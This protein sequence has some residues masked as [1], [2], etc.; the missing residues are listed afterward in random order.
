[1]TRIETETPDG[2]ETSRSS[3]FV[4]KK[5]WTAFFL[6]LTIVFLSCAVRFRSDNFSRLIEHDELL[7]VQDY[8]W[9]GVNADGTRHEIRNISDLTGLSSCSV[10]QFAIG[11]YCSLGRWIEPN[12]HAYHSLLVNATLA[13]MDEKIEASRLPALLAAAG[14]G[15]VCAGLCCWA[16]YYFTAPLVTAICLWHPYVVSFSQSCRGYALVLF[17]TALSIFWLSQLVKNSRSKL[18]GCLMAIS[19]CVLLMTMVNLAV[20]WVAP[21][22]LVTFVFLPMLCEPNSSESELRSIRQNLLFQSLGICAVG[23]VF[24][25]DR[26]PYLYASATQYGIPIETFSD[27]IGRVGILAGYLFPTVPFKLFAILSCLGIITACK[28]RR[29]KLLIVPYLAALVISLAH[30][31]ITYR[32]PY[33]RNIGFVLPLFLFGYASLTETAIRFFQSRYSQGATFVCSILF[34]AWCLQ[35]SLEIELEDTA[36]RELVHSLENMEERSEESTLVVTGKG[37]PM[38]VKLY[39]P[40]NWSLSE[41]PLQDGEKVTV[42]LMENQTRPPL[43]SSNGETSISNLLTSSWPGAVKESIACYDQWTLPAVLHQAP[44]PEKTPAFHMAVWYPPFHVVSVS[45][46][47]VLESLEKAR[48]PFHEIHERYQAKLDVY[49]R[50]KCVVIPLKGLSETTETRDSAS[51]SAQRSLQKIHNRHGGRLVYLYAVE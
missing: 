9:A 28:T 22:Y 39:F 32:F 33:N 46:S 50:L 10:R 3:D 15:I 18:I 41:V 14:F 8:T 13:V 24:F 4:R 27:G 2:P 11:C 16:G 34:V 30:F 47:A 19:S 44:I 21:F 51:H 5:F 17:L 23:F 38:P 1:V 20:D 12:N 6:S 45:P 26:L 37:V 48:L 25:F 31:F 29:G 36:F 7:T 40:E 35:P 43:F 42:R 49:D